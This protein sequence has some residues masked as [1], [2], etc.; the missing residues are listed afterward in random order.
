M[1]ALFAAIPA[2]NRQQSTLAE[3]WWD[4]LPQFE[5]H[6]NDLDLFHNF[7]ISDRDPVY[8]PSCTLCRETWERWKISVLQLESAMERLLGGR[9]QYD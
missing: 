4:G 2:P 5:I 1:K 6:E 3:G 9:A 7:T 8:C